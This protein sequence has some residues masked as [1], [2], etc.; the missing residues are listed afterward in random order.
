MY[1]YMLTELIMILYL[2]MYVYVT[3]CVSIMK[4]YVY[5]RTYTYMNLL[6]ALLEYYS[7]CTFY[8]LEYEHSVDHISSFL[9]T[10]CA[11]Q[12]TIEM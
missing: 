4:T 1:D 11:Y 8:I 10:L 3:P 5:A 12:I 2:A 6:I 9:L 7:K